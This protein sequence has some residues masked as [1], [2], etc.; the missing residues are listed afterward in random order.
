MMPQNHFDPIWEEKYA[1]GHAQRYP[2]DS[3]VSFVCR[4][5]PR[6]KARQDTRILEVGCGTGANLWFAAREGFQVAGIDASGSAIACARKRFQEEGIQGDLR[7]AYFTQLPF[8]R[9]S[10]DLVIDRC[11]LTCCGFGVAKRAI[12]E[13]RRVLCRGGKFLF[14]SYSDRHSSSLSGRKGEDG[15]ILDISEGT[16]VG[17]GQICF[18]GRSQVTMLLE[19][20]WKLLSVEHFELNQMLAPQFTLHS[21][22][23]VIAEK[24]A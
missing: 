20:G 17:V 14:N 23:R 18:Y 8:E 5:S 6:E 9:E 11:S 21:E 15:L 24:I 12:T 7:V 1:R 3:I 10:F 2:W 19:Q 22:W 16:L 4:F 13:I